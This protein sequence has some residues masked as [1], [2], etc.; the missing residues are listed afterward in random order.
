MLVSGTIE[1]RLKSKEAARS[2]FSAIGTE[3]GSKRAAIKRRVEGAKLLISIEAK[4]AVAYRALAN[5]VLRSLQ[6]IEGMDK[7][8]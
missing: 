1:V 6:V 2:A 4:D 7:I 8:K 5:S 3:S